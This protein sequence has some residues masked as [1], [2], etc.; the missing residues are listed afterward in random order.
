MMSLQALVGIVAQPFIM[1]VCAAGKTEWEGRVGFTVGNLVKRLC[2]IAWSLTAIAAVAW[3]LQR[4]VD[5]ASV[6]PDHIYGDVAQAFLP[7]LG[8]GVLGLFL[9]AVLAGVMSSCDAFMVSSAALFTENVYKAA[10]P[11]QS[12]RHY[13]WIGRCISVVVVTGGVVFALWVPT[14]VKALEIWFMI[15][16]MMGLVFWMGLLW[17]RLTVVG[18]WVTTL[19]GFATWWATTQSWFIDGVTQMPVA[20]TWRLLWVEDGKTA[21]YLPWQILLYMAVAVMAGVL[22]S[23]FTRQVPQDKLERFYTLSRTPIAPG[24]ELTEPCFLPP[25]TTPAKRTMLVTAGGLEIPRPSRVSLIG[26]GVI[27][28]CVAV[29]IGGFIAMV[30]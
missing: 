20:G 28:I 9:A 17:R 8:P 24:E 11:G 26:F 10:V 18:A 15:A 19:S 12:Q 30:S 1:G 23:L 3:Y 5:L 16:P 6:K 21:L 4:G 13:V 29:M 22:V 2:T 7:K 14:V 25:S 27:W